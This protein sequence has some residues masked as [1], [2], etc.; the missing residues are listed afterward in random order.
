MSGSQYALLEEAFSADRPGQEAVPAAPPTVSSLPSREANPYAKLPGGDG[1][2]SE[3]ADAVIAAAAADAMVGTRTEAGG[4]DDVGPAAP[5]APAAYKAKT[6]GDGGAAWR[7]RQ[8]LRMRER[9]KEEGRSV[10]EVLEESGATVGSVGELQSDI[11]RRRAKTRHASGGKLSK[12]PFQKPEEAK[13]QSWAD[14]NRAR[15]K[16][17]IVGGG[18]GSATGRS[19]F[20]VADAAGPSAGPLRPVAGQPAHDYTRE[21]V[22]GKVRRPASARTRRVNSFTGASAT[23]ACRAPAGAL[24][25]P[26]LPGRREEGGRLSAPPG[27]C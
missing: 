17:A 24:T 26:T 25:R 8:L 6:I 13:D 14:I 23:L 10:A 19:A 1:L 2:P 20:G 21:D 9:A 5:A 15:R 7:Q 12:A 18:G 3:E 11:Q 22:G 16:A 27:D 4:D